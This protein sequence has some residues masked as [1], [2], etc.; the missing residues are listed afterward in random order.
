MIRLRLW[1][2]LLLQGVMGL[3]LMA[4]PLYLYVSTTE[5]RISY[6]LK[7]RQGLKPGAT[8]MRLLQYVQQH[9][10]LSAAFPGGGLL[11]A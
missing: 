7:E 11:Q 5:A 9:R 10:G 2:K 4:P 6:S 8:A 3:L 1:Q